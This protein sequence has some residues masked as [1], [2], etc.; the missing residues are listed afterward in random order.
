MDL[1]YDFQLYDLVNLLFLQY[2]ESVVVMVVVVVE[3]QYRHTRQS[4]STVTART[5]V[6][7]FLGL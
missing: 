5:H 7:G 2:E 1:F 4:T 3:P 6:R